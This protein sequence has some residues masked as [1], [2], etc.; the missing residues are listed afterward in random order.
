[1]AL[2]KVQDQFALRTKLVMWGRGYL[3]KLDPVTFAPCYGWVREVLTTNH[4]RE[5]PFLLISVPRNT[6]PRIHWS[7]HLQK[8]ILSLS[9]S[10]CWGLTSDQSEYLE[11][12]FSPFWQVGL[13]SCTDLFCSEG[14]LMVL[15]ILLNVVHM[16][17]VW[18]T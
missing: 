12:S 5:T 9:W 8:V 16:T 1:M 17:E 6:Q 18:V 15:G 3:L 10:R 11:S 7:L 13:S 4:L 2:P 14:K